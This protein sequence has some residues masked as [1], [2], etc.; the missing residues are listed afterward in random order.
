MSS[1]M[2]TTRRMSDN[3]HLKLGGLNTFLVAI[4]TRY[5]FFLGF[6]LWTQIRESCQDMH[7]PRGQPLVTRGLGGTER[8]CNYR[9]HV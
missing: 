5:V 6:I 4:T 3:E 8:C 7:C 1:F 2:A 9:I